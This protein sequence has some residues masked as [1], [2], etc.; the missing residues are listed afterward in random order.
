MSRMMKTLERQG[1]RM[2]A[3]VAWENF[4]GMNRIGGS[5]LWCDQKASRDALVVLLAQHLRPSHP[6]ATRERAK[7]AILRFTGT[8]EGAGDLGIVRA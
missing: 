2:Q 7:K 4:Y 1:S 3:Q 5:R 8:A 6:C